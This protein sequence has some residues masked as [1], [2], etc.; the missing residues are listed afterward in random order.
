VL[1]GPAIQR[2][3]LRAAAGNP[4]Q[5]LFE[6]V[7]HLEAAGDWELYNRWLLVPTMT[8][9][10]KASQWLHPR[11]ALIVFVTATL[12]LVQKERFAT[13]GPLDS[14]AFQLA[15]YDENVTESEGRPYSTAAEALAIKGVKTAFTRS[16]VFWCAPLSVSVYFGIRAALELMVNARSSWRSAEHAKRLASHYSATPSSVG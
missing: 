5:A 2:I 14:F 10:V 4:R 9:H 1:I 6:L 12:L 11:L 7:T 8:V 16:L 3:Q 13:V 15:T